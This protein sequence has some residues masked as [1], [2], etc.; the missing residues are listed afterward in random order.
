MTFFF[1]MNPIGV[2]LKMLL[3]LLSFRMGVDGCF[4]STVLKQS[5]KECASIIKRASHG[6]G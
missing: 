6:L 4:C 5:N 1:Q 2:I 3:A